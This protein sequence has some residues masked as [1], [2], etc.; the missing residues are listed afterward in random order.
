MI[1]GV[2]GVVTLKETELYDKVTGLKRLRT[3][4]TTDVSVEM[5]Y[6]YVIVWYSVEIISTV[7][8]LTQKRYLVKG[9]LLLLGQNV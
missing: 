6:C 8:R 5:M 1:G 3:A 4:S 7:T 2:G 9:L